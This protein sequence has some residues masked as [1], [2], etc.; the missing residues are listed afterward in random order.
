MQLKEFTT[1]THST[2]RSYWISLKV[3]IPSLVFKI[4]LKII[5]I[6]QLIEINKLKIKPHFFLSL[7]SKSYVQIFMQ[8]PIRKGQRVTTLNLSE[9]SRKL[10][11]FCKKI[12]RICIIKKGLITLINGNL[13]LQKEPAHKKLFLIQIIYK[14][15]TKM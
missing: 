10:N 8:D 6:L 14:N 13:F 5:L 7:E 4:I 12:K 2:I 3:K 15:T 11:W 1:W 9:I